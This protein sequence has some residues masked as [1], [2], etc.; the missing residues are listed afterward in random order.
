M[1]DAPVQV[2]LFVPKPKNPPTPKKDNPAKDAICYQCGEGLKGSRKLKPGTLSLYG[3][4]GHRATVKVI[5]DF[6]LY[7]ACMSRKMARKLYAHQVERAKDLLGLIHTDNAEFLKNS[8]INHEASGSI[9]DLEIIQ[10]ED[11][12]PSLDTSLNH[13]EHDQEI[14]EPQSDTKPIRRSTRTRHLTDGLCLYIDAEERELGDLCKPANYKATL[15]DPESDKWLNSMNVDMQSMKDNEVW[16]LVVL[17]PNG[18]VI[19]IRAIKILIYIIA[20]YDYE[21]WQMDVITAFLNGYLNKERL[22]G[23]F[24]FRLVVVPRIEEPINMY[25]DNTGAIAIAKDHGVTKGEKHFRIK[26]HYLRETIEMDKKTMAVSLPQDVI[27]FQIIT[28]VPTKSV[29]RFKCV[30]KQWNSF[31]MSDK[32][33]EMH[34]D[35]NLQKVFVYPHLEPQNL[36]LLYAGTATFYTIDCELPPDNSP[37]SRPLPQ[38]VAYRSPRH[39]SILTS[40]HGLVCV[41]IEK[42]LRR[43]FDIILWNPV[44]TEYKRLSKPSNPDHMECYKGS[45][46]VY[47]LYY[48]SDTKSPFQDDLRPGV[49]LNENLY[50]QSDIITDSSLR[51]DTKAKRFHK[52]KNPPIPDGYSPWTKITVENGSIHLCV[53]YDSI[54]ELWKFIANGDIWTKVATYQPNHDIFDFSPGHLTSNGNLLM[55]DSIKGLRVFQVDLKKK[56]YTKDKKDGPERENYHDGYFIVGCPEDIIYTETFVSPNRNMKQSSLPPGSHSGTDRGVRVLL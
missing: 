10:D 40:F 30:S 34:N 19:D 35:H 49:C 29:D 44:T 55:I 36:F 8:L 32:F 2:P 47:G 13:K 14:D 24:I 4:V 46:R 22:Y 52:I 39:T 20:F 26:V 25:S 48:C 1:G 51:F 42:N 9:D 11:T 18:K 38:F 53:L 41:G 27:L 15:F 12:H 54:I 31:L 7:V 50:F 33:K 23:K 6:H 21:I 16:E 56:N 37:C 45:G 5:V 43:D 3:G 17:P 28:R